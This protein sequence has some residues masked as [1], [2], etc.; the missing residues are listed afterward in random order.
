MDHTSGL[1]RVLLTRAY[2]SFFVVLGVAT[3]AAHAE[4]PERFAAPA[5]SELTLHDC[6]NLAFAQQP[7]LAAAQASL[8]AAEIGQGALKKMILA[9]LIARD[10]PIR[11]QQASLGVTIASAGLLQAE[12]ETR[13]AVT[14]N[15]YSFVYARQQERVVK[16]VLEKLDVARDKAKFFVDKGDPKTKVTQIDV[17]TLTVNI[18]FYKA[19]QAEASVGIER[20]LA[21]LREAIGLSHDY[22][23]AVVEQDLPPLEEVPGREELIEL[24]LSRRGEMMQ[25]SAAREVTALEVDAQGKSF[26]PT[27]KTF[28]AASDVHARPIP[29]GVAN[30]E[31]RPGAIGI[32]MPPFMVGR[33][34]DRQD[35]V[36][37]YEARASSVVEKTEILIALEADA[38]YLKW[39][40]AALRVKAL[41]KTTALAKKIGDNVNKRFIDTGNVPGDELI[42]ARTLEDQAQAAYNE[43]L[44]LHA[45]ALATLERVTAGGYLAACFVPARP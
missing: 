42:R 39:K 3:P 36:R 25:A 41:Q 7:T 30:T 6:L 17:D 15:Y 31:Y 44:Y 28:G 14:R 11:R 4:A 2:I 29:Q 26:M 38:A 8:D 43:A 13:Y 33:R 35:R 27:M 23:L 19:R 20:A 16:S 34:R 45:L 5:A 1:W 12:W 9:R 32:E 10:L 21:A 22:P 37:A 18:D 40:E 24:A